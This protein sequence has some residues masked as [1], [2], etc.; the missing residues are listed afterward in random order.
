MAR[1]TKLVKEDEKKIEV[2]EIEDHEDV[3]DEL[4][5]EDFDFEDEAEE[6][7]EE[8]VNEDAAA[9]NAASVQTDSSKFAKMSMA[10][11][12][13]NAMKG[14][15]VNKLLASLQQN[16]KSLAAGVPDGAAAKNAASVAMK[17]AVKEDLDVLFGDDKEL[18]EDFKTKV[19]TLF[20]AA[21]ENRLALLEAELVEKYDS[22]LDEEVAEITEGLITKVD[23]YLNYVAEEWLKANEVAVVSTLRA[24]IAE[25]VISGLHNVFVENNITIPEDKIDIV[26]QLAAENADLEAKLDAAITE[27]ISLKEEISGFE[28]EMIFSDVAEGLALTSVEKF[29]TLAEAVTYDGD[30]EKYAKKLSIIK[31]KYFGADAASAKKT[32]TKIVTEE[33][34]HSDADEKVIKT[35]SDPVMRLYEQSLNAGSRVKSH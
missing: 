3:S 20:E 5:D 22:Q 6:A 16:S 26:E 31:E 23:E 25:E 18:S 29:H 34:V 15:E 12:L 30:A 14:D 24:D 28:K 19:S 8:D 21:V 33:I 17:S 32:N 7:V 10:I 27:N 4:E 11:T 35:S 2:E 1:K 9:K 13:M